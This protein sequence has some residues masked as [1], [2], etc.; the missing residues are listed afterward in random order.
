MAT[1]DPN[2]AIAGTLAEPGLSET[3]TRALIAANQQLG[4]LAGPVQVLIDTALN[5]RVPTL[6]SQL[7][8]FV[9]ALQVKMTGGTLVETEILALQQNNGTPSPSAPTIV[10]APTVDDVTPTVDQLITI[11]PSSV[12][13]A[14]LRSSV[15]TFRV[16]FPGLVGFQPTYQSGLTYRI[17]AIALGYPM[18]VTQRAADSVVSSVFVERDSLLTAAVIGVPPTVDV[19]P[20][21][22]PAGAQPLGTLYTLGDGT[23]TPHTGASIQSRDWQVY[24]GGVAILGGRQLTNQFQ[25]DSSHAGKVV[26]FDVVG[27]DDLGLRSNP[28]LC[29]NSSTIAGAPYQAT[30]PPSLAATVMEGSIDPIVGAIWPTPVTVL[31]R[32][33]LF[34]G[35]IIIGATLPAAYLFYKPELPADM[36][37]VLLAAG[38]TRTALASIKIKEYVTGPDGNQYTSVSDPEVIQAASAALALS[39]TSAGEAG[40]FWTVGE[41]ISPA[42]AAAASGGNGIYSYTWTGLP[43]GVTLS[44]GGTQFPA[45]GTPSAAL[46]LANTSVTVRDS[47]GNVAGPVAVVIQVSPA[48]SGITPNRLILSP[49]YEIEA[50]NDADGSSYS[51]KQYTNGA[52]VPPLSSLPTITRGGVVRFG[53]TTLSGLPVLLHRVLRSDPLRNSGARSEYSMDDFRFANGEDVWFSQVYLFGSD[54]APSGNNSDRQIIQ[55]IHQDATSTF[56][57][58]GLLVAGGGSRQGLNWQVSSGG[59][60]LFLYNTPVVLNQFIRVITHYRSG[61]ASSGHAPKMEAWVAYGSASSY[62]KLAPLFAGADTQ[63]FGE[64]LS[65]PGSNNDWSKIGIYNWTGVLGAQTS[66]SLWSSGL[67]A[68]KGLALFD[69]AAAP[70]APYALGN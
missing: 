41:Q 39:L 23:I 66:R 54:W 32:E 64:P 38:Y 47:A 14:T 29:S 59:S 53:P 49:N 22:S 36:P 13:D 42:I 17:P 4:L 28:A 8:G 21:I 12:T 27:V 10:S 15:N 19:A 50:P 7:G 43:A 35:D 56:N 48:Q 24:V 37:S 58:F 67:Y 52:N 51:A 45:T 65:T 11:S 5:A 1:R 25:S 30:T 60:D 68:R 20:T 55:N 62:T 44:S 3:E 2:S 31:R 57:P 69:E 33:I 9:P 6:L 70:L 18:L 63:S 16:S 46:P 40:Y 61:F 26:T 34:D